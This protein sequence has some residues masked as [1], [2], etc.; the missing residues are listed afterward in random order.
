MNTWYR[1]TAAGTAIVGT[2]LN[3]ALGDSMSLPVTIGG[4][5]YGLYVPVWG[6][7]IGTF[8]VM[9]MARRANKSAWWSALGSLG[10]LL[11]PVIAYAAWTIKGWGV[12]DD[13]P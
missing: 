4:S 11:G 10:F 2:V 12:R 8:F 1:T 3:K 7:I 9:R 13:N 5:V 6:V